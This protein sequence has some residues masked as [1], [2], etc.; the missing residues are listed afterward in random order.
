MRAV[1]SAGESV[2]IARIAEPQARPDGETVVVDVASSGICGTDL[3]LLSNGVEATLGHEFAG[4][5]ADGTAVCVQPSV[6][7]GTC[8]GCEAGNEQ[9]CRTHLERMYGVSLDGGLADK[10][11]V[12]RKCLVPLPAGVAPGIGALVEPLAVAVH[13]IHQGG[14]HAGHRVLV[15]GGGTV[16]LTTVAAALAGGADVDVV[17]R[18]DHQREAAD[19][20]GAGLD[21]S[22]EYDVTFDAAGSQSALDMAIE[23]VRPAGSVVAVGLYWEPVTIGFGLLTK[24]VRL[25]PAFMYGHHHGAREFVQATAILAAPRWWQTP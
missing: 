14:V 6:P 23:H 5:L 10:V 22:G 21:P 3:H 20:L 7:C 16:G 24:E 19:A 4:V 1:R 12:N 8:D 15:V 25:V 9:V 13:A 2:Q 11:L 18:H 17:V